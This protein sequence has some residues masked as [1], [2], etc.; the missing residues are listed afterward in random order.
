MKIISHNSTII[1]E[2]TTEV[3]K[4]DLEWFSIFRREAT[5]ASLS[6]LIS[7]Y[8]DRLICLL[9]LILLTHL[10]GLKFTTG[11]K[12]K[13]KNKWYSGYIVAARGGAFCN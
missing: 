8:Y 4:K 6:I 13:R 7:K 10:T 3:S 12:E 2:K 11:N 1:A 9:L 5:K